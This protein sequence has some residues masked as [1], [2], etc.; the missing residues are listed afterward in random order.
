LRLAP[1]REHVLCR[2]VLVFPPVVLPEEDLDGTPRGLDGVRVG[3][4]VGI[5]KVD[6][7][8]DGAV[9]ETL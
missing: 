6:G 8:V 9:R 2:V 5:Y 4:G 1:H 3:P 7:V